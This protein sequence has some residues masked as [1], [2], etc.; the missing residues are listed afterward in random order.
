MAQ[1]NLGL[2]LAGGPFEEKEKIITEIRLKRIAEIKLGDDMHCVYCG[3][4]FKATK[5]TYILTQDQEVVVCPHCGHMSDAIEYMTM[6]FENDEKPVI[7]SVDIGRCCGRW[8]LK[9]A[10]RY[11]G[12]ERC[13]VAFLT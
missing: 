13:V 10:Y 5:K 6:R 12:E 11:G 8:T 4:E 7:E 3:E 1:S 9:A 2:G